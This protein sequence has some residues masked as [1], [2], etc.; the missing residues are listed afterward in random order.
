V[1]YLRVHRDQV[2]T[3]YRTLSYFDGAVMATRARVPALFSVALMDDTCPPSTVYAAHN[4]WAGPKQIRV[5]PF[6][7]HEGG[8]AE[9]QRAQLD[10][11]RAT[12]AR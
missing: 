8:G 11:L 1:T 4:A 12:L 7:G 2:D 3:V 10:W 9:Q 6:N 5:Y